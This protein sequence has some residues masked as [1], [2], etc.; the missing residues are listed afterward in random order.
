MVLNEWFGELT[1]AH[2]SEYRR[3]DDSIAHLA[4]GAT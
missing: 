2:W 1:G 4:I 3:H